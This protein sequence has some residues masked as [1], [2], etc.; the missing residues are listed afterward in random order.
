MIL[1]HNFSDTAHSKHKPYMFRINK[2]FVCDTLKNV[3]DTQM[4]CNAPFEKNWSKI[5]RLNMTFDLTTH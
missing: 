4:C 1:F 2:N 5:L 3:S